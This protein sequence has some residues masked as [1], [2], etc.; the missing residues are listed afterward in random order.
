MR[1][2]GAVEVGT[3]PFGQPY[4][5]AT[6][7]PDLDKKPRTVI[8]DNLTMLDARLA[9]V[10]LLQTL[11]DVLNLKIDI[12]GLGVANH[13]L[14]TG[15]VRVGETTA[16]G[17]LNSF[18]NFDLALYMPAPG[19]TAVVALVGFPELGGDDP[20]PTT[21]G[22][23]G[24]RYTN[25]ILIQ[26]D[27]GCEHLGNFI[28]NNN[29]TYQDCQRDLIGY[30]PTV[31]PAPKVEVKRWRRTSN[32]SLVDTPVGTLT[33][34]EE[35]LVTDPGGDTFLNCPSFGMEFTTSPTYN[36]YS[37]T[38]INNVTALRQLDYS[39][40]YLQNPLVSGFCPNIS[41]INRPTRGENAMCCLVLP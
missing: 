13:K 18:A 16:T 12:A 34:G 17:Y 31:C 26:G 40:G 32:F 15:T 5:I 10:G 27:D 19:P 39:E 28:S 1:V 24:P 41:G 30:R 29:P 21:P 6:I 35:R 23:T 25:C 2:G 4:Q 3:S 14:I 33:T 8:Y 11:P 37:I 22:P 38:T 20:T 9:R 36:S 7:V